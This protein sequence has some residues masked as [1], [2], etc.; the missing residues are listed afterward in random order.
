MSSILLY[1]L[2]GALSA[3]VVLGTYI[4]IRSMLLKGQKY[5]IINKAEIEDEG[6]KK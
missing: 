4:L 3:A 6:I 5:E 1:I 2:V